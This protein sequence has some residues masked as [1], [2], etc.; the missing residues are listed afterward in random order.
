MNLEYFISKN[1]IKGDRNSKKFT[2]PIINISI[3]AIALGLIVMIIAISIVGGFQR[4]IRNKVI[5]FGSHIQ[6]TNFDSQN[7]YEASPIDKNQDFY[8]SIDTINGIKHIQQFATKAGIIKTKEEIYGVVVKGV[9][10]D[11]DWN[12]FSQK[13]VDGDIFTVDSESTENSI[14][15]SKTISDKMKLKVDDKMFVYFIQENGELRPKNFIVKGIY[16][17]GLEQ[18]DNLYVIA[19]IAHIQ[20]RN[21][22]T[23]DQIGGFEVIIDDYN[24]IDELG[25]YVYD[26]I[27][28]DLHSTTIKELNPDIF[29]WL[30]L[31][32]YNVN[33]I[34]ILMIL[35]AVINIISALLILILERTN[36]IG[37]LKALGMPNWNVRKIF[38]YNA[39]YLILKGLIWGNVIGISLCIIQLQTGIFTLPEESYYVAV[40]PIELNFFK[41]LILN[42]G[43]LIICIS[44]LLIPSYVITKISPVKAIRFD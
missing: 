5:G 12:F 39:A 14:L 35:V 31:Q 10:N 26:N 7:T 20:K 18:F 33:I 17:T 30:A 37:I 11:F 24:R 2:K 38:L 40:V 22:W 8:P 23:K 1:I 27:G 43:T 25:E 19:D 21:G 3:I 32:D 13:I 36:M 44:L 28:Y 16:Q 9:A 15:L 34:I 41:I 29:N 6:I 4:E 42:I